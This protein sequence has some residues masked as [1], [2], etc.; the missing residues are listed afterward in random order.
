[1]TLRSEFFVVSIKLHMTNT[2]LFKLTVFKI[3]Y[4]VIKIVKL[5]LILIFERRISKQKKWKDAQTSFYPS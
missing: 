2:F 5:P 4:F 1:M 3:Y